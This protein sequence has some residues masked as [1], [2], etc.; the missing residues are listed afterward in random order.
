MDPDSK[1][2]LIS[3]L[4]ALITSAIA[5]AA[6]LAIYFLYRVVVG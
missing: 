4:V 6:V 3:L 5:T 2:I 1:V